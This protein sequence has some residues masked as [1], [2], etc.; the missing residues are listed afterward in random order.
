MVSALTIDTRQLGYE[1]DI[2]LGSWADKL[3]GFRVFPDG[4][5]LLEGGIGIGFEFVAQYDHNGQWM[6]S[7]PP[8][9][10]QQTHLF[11]EYQYQML[12]LAANSEHA[13]QLLE[14]RPVL[15]ALICQLHSVDNEKA[16]EISALGQRDILNAVGLDGTKAALKF[17]DKLELNYEKGDELDHIRRVLDPLSQRYLKFKHYP[18]IGYVALRLDQIHPFLTGSKLGVAMTKAG[19]VNG[20]TRIA[21][22][23]DAVELARW[24]DIADP[25]RQITRQP[26]IEAFEQLHD[27]WVDLRNRRR[28]EQQLEKQVKPEDVEKRY[29]QPFSGNDVIEP[30][31]NYRELDKEGLELKH[32][33]GIYH[34]RIT[35]QRYC[36]FRMTAPERLSIGIKVLAKR[37][38]F[39]FEIE[40]I[41]GLRNSPP[42]E[43]SRT[44]IYE[45]FQQCRE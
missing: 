41:S 30:I 27:R 14:K 12:W 35:Q 25:I 45:W 24:L 16:L 23:Q 32:C 44:I 7:I 28:V 37:R 2:E 31:I 3:V 17:L 43:E 15:L 39:P 9:Y 33:I 38:S 19:L 26:S 1:F 34:S 21:F 11:P 36:A 10:L 13:T 8:H 20:A 42:S 5:Q 18:R 6:Q 4:K 29:W 40:Q 22:F